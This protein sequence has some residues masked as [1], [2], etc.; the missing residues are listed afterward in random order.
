MRL[1]AAAVLALLWPGLAL[2]QPSFDSAKATT[3][4]ERAICGS[5]KLAAADRELATVFG[6]LAGKLSGA[7]K[8]HLLQDQLGI[9]LE[10]TG[11]PGGALEIGKFSRRQEYLFPAHL[12]LI[13]R[14]GQVGLVVHKKIDRAMG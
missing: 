7:A 8:E 3:P 11:I 12:E 13:G 1:R 6:A 4:V 9:I 5:T 14:F 10:R 2:A